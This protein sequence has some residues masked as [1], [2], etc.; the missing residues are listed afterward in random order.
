VTTINVDAAMKTARGYHHAAGE[1]EALDRQKTRPGVQANIDLAYIEQLVGRI[2]AAVMLEALAVELVLK[3]RLQRAG[4]SFARLRDKHDHLA[5]YAL[6]PDLE[7]QEADRR[8]Q[9]SRLSAMRATLS[10]ALS[11]SAKVFVRFRYMHE[12]PSVEA[13]LGEMQRAFKALAEGM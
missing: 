2:G 4:I 1:L 5:L 12:Q 13:S 6:L 7:K 3:A 10:D 8:Y 9:S 11:Y